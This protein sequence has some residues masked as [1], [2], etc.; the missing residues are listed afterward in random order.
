[1]V[2]ING[3]K[4]RPNI[5]MNNMLSVLFS[6]EIRLS[7]RFDHYFPCFRLHVSITMVEMSVC[8]GELNIHTDY[9]LLNNGEGLRIKRSSDET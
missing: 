5:V 8:V 6:Q 3:H 2:E 9:T 1:M 4:Y 7:I